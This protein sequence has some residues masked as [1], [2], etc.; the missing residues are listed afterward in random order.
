MHV[1]IHVLSL[2]VQH[3]FNGQT[4]GEMLE[5]VKFYSFTHEL[6]YELHRILKI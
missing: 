1:D 6:I 2:N 4:S 3:S 5:N